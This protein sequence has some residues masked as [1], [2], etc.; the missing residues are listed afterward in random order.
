MP[1]MAEIHGFPQA[2]LE[3]RRLCTVKRYRAR[4]DNHR[5]SVGRPMHLP[6]IWV[7][8]DKVTFESGDED[9]AKSK[10]HLAGV[11]PFLGPV[12]DPFVAVRRPFAF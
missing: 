12:L 11:D 3:F 10:E 8:A 2:V 7:H 9:A 4:D 5:E 6:G 1:V